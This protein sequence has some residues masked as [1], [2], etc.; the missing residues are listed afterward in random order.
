MIELTLQSGEEIKLPMTVDDAP[1]K[2]WFEMS[3]RERELEKLGTNCEP[4]DFIRYITDAVKS[5]VYIPDNL[6]F[7]L[8]AI[9]L[10]N[11]EWELNPE[12]IASVKSK[13]VETVEATVL[14]VYRTCF[15]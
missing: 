4:S 11:K 7:G 14:N 10:K 3:A 9:S 5:V 12:F 6:V 1:A 15:G 13:G 8:P 2:A